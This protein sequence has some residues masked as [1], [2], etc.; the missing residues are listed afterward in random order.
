MVNG[1]RTRLVPGTA[2]K[3]RKNGSVHREWR[4]VRAVR[5]DAE[6]RTARLP[7]CPRLLRGRQPGISGPVD[8][9]ASR[10]LKSKPYRAPAE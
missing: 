1:E 6:A 9:R 3:R 4:S 10:H 5:Q 7:L 2:W 8:R